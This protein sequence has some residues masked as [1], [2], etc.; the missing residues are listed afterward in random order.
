MALDLLSPGE[1]QES[2]RRGLGRESFKSREVE[3]ITI[4]ELNFC[5]FSIP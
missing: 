4:G 2:N 3:W 5:V 1:L